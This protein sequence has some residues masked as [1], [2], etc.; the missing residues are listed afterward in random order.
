MIPELVTKFRPKS[1]LAK[2]YSKI[3]HNRTIGESWYAEQKCGRTKRLIIPYVR[4]WPRFKQ[5]L[6]AD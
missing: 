3:A 1:K 2:K 6:L 4:T 5:C